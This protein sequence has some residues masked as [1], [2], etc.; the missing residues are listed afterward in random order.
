M[1]QQELL[2]LIQLEMM[3]FL[4]KVKKEN[5]KTLQNTESFFYK[6]KVFKQDKRKIVN[7]NPRGE[8]LLHCISQRYH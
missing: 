6:S 7:P 1:E 8:E 2:L 3:T 5:N 4:S